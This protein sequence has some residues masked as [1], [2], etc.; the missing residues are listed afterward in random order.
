[1]EKQDIKTMVEEAIADKAFVARL[2]AITTVEDAQKAFAEKGIVL[3]IEEIQQIAD[4]LSGKEELSEI[5]LDNVAGG[6]LIGMTAVAV[7]V[8]GV[9]AVAGIKIAWGK[10]NSY[11]K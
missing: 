8:L 3:T 11:L 4:S 7:V 5:D 10:L 6:S 9:L 2:E 1:M